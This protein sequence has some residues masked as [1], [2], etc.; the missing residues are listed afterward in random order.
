MQALLELDC[1][2]AGMELFPAADEDQ[3]TLIQRVIDDC[4]YYIVIVGGR[5]GTLSPDGIS[6]TQKEYEYAVQQGKPVMGFTHSD[7]GSIPAAKSELDKVAQEKLADFKKL[8]QQKM[9]KSWSTPP[10]LGSVVSR[11][12]VQLIKRNP[13]IGWVRGNLVPDESAS[14][15]ILKL[16]KHVEEL[17]S[18]LD[19]AGNQPPAGTEVLA[20]GNDEFLLRL[21]YHEPSDTLETHKVKMSWHE[22]IALLGPYLIDEAS[23]YKLSHVISISAA[24]LYDLPNHYKYSYNDSFVSIRDD[25]FQTIKVQLRALGLIEQSMRSRSVKDNYT[26]WT[27]TPY[28]NLVVTRM[29]AIRR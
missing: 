18:A 22:I 20:Q 28:G 8:V 5:Y 14:Q 26:Y 2:P 15:E 11:S 19:S 4:D 1:I 24:H 29:R 23:E 12:L 21:D 7:P 10:E 16:R 6:Y 27:L 25:D 3:W 9:C 13:A 17:E